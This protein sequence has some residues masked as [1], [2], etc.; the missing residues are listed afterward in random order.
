MSRPA[1]A[2]AV[3]LLIVLA[4]AAGRAANIF[5]NLS[6]TSAPSLDLDPSVRSAGMGSAATA[7]AWG[8]DPNDWANP[9]LLGLAEGLRYTQGDTRLY[10]DLDPGV[11]FT[12]QRFVL[13]HGGFG[14]ALSGQPVSGLGGSKLD[15]GAITVHGPYV[16]VTFHALERVRDWGVGVSAGALARTLGTAPAWARYAD[17]AV[18]Y[19]QRTVQSE[20]GPL[21]TARATASDLGM[22]VRRHA[23]A[24]CRG[25][26]RAT[27]GR[28]R[29]R[30]ARLR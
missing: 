4:P 26:R 14:L 27:R 5:E 10:P 11:R 24:A 28:L 15:Y 9:A 7:L 3:V 30:G 13:G 16:P 18:G 12:S 6:L 19:Q 23:A 29:L 25:P 17:L 21:G 20:G 2:L 8:V 1:T 22:L